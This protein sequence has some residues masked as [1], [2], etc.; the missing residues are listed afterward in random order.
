VRGAPYCDDDPAY[1]EACAALRGGDRGA[2]TRA[3]QAMRG[4]RALVAVAHLY[5]QAGR[6]VDAEEKLEQAMRDGGDPWMSSNTSFTNGLLNDVQNRLG[7]IQIDCPRGEVAIG[8]SGVARRYDLPRAQPL[9]APT[10]HVQ[11]VISQAG[12]SMQQY[13]DVR[14]GQTARVTNCGG[15]S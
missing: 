12:S 10:G 11:V 13:V 6:L 5:R 2:A 8:A 4:P 3:F 15:G 7:Y 1:L 9:R 14:S